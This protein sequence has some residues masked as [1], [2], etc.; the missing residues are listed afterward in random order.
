MTFDRRTVLAGLATIPFAGLARGGAARA[1][2][3]SAG[4][5]AGDR[6]ATSAGEIVLHPVS[7]ASLVIGFADQV[8]YVDP[9]GGAEAFAGLPAA[10]AVLVTHGHGDHFDLPTLEAVAGGDVPL[11]VSGEV[12]EK[13]PAALKPK[14]QGVPNGESREIAGITVDA[15]PAYNTTEERKQYH[16]RG[17]GN[18]Y[19]LNIG[20]K[21]IY[22]AGDTEDVP[23]MRA[24]TGIEVAFLP[25]NLPYTMTEEQAA[26]AVKAFRPR[27][28]Y[29]YHYRDS[30]PQKFA[31]LV[32]DAAEVRLVDWYAGGGH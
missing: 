7:H 20:D 16:P 9:V 18:G 15:V 31:D 29:P 25:M 10:T 32:G 1:Q 22:V 11:L 8:V 23:E 26:D 24:L 12:Y 13:L 5:L 2:D 6:V 27:I 4:A 28:V 19:V 30:D 3:S 14:A 17:V 21:K